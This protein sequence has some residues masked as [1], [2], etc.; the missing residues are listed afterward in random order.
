MVE[1]WSSD[2]QTLLDRPSPAVLTTYRK[3]GSA[4]VSPVW[5]RLHEQDLEVVI[6]E[7]DAKLRHLE[8]VPRCSLMVFETEPPFR[9]LTI[10]GAPRL[11]PDGG[12][13]ARLAIASRYLGRELGGR[14]VE[15]RR[16][17]G[18]VL[19]IDPIEVRE[20]DLS[21]IIPQE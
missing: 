16:T 11:V 5:F 6:A 12:N 7:G 19:R 8:R 17:P 21:G 9:G 20:W 10:E 3:D 13:T 1:A 15:Q 2:S 18:L 14:F 4:A